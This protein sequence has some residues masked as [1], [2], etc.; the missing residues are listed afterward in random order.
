[1]VAPLICATS[2]WLRICWRRSAMEKRDKGRPVR[3]GSS[4]ARAFT[5][6]TRRGGKAGLTPASRFILEAGQASQTEALAPLADDLAWRVE[7]RG[8]YII[9]EA[10][11]GQQDD[12]GANDITIR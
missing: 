3:C 10:L 6:T 4:Q 9:G 11:G 12:F 2:P 5:C 8:N 7:S 1:M